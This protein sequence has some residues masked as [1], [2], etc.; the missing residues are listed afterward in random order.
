[1]KSR[2]IGSGGDDADAPTWEAQIDDS[3]SETGTCIE[4]ANLSGGALVLNATLTGGHTAL[5]TAHANNMVNAPTWGVL[6]SK[7]RMEGTS[8]PVVNVTAAGFTV[9]KI[10]VRGTSGN[11][12]ALQTTADATLRRLLLAA[13][14]AA[15]G[16]TNNG[17]T[18]TVSNC[19]AFGADVGFE[20]AAGTVNLYHCSAVGN[21]AFGFA[22]YV[23]TYNC[24]ACI[25]QG[26]VTAD[27]FTP[28]GGDYNVSEDSTAPGSASTKYARTETG[29]FTNETAT[30]EDLSLVAGKQGWWAANKDAI[31]QTGWPSDVGTDIV[32][33]SRSGVDIDPGV[34]Q[35]PAGGGSVVPSNVHHFKQQGAM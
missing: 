3:D 18:V 15:A 10:G 31:D 25:S 16:H 21:A 4:S 9:E 8:S 35:T 29:W 28:S 26:A 22:R 19:A 7:A 13:S 34:W 17:G 30:S 6:T 24:Y 14:S 11:T 1:M 27:F 23:G 32:G 33:T 12:H 5:L 20:S 2:T